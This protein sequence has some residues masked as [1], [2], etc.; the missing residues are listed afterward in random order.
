M[1]IMKFISC[2][3]LPMTILSNNITYSYEDILGIG[4]ELIINNNTNETLHGANIIVHTKPSDSRNVVIKNV[5]RQI[6][7]S[8]EYDVVSV[9][10]NNGIYSVPDNSKLQEQG[11]EVGL[12]E[13]NG[14]LYIANYRKVNNNIHWYGIDDRITSAWDNINKRTIYYPY[15]DYQPVWTYLGSTPVF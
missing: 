5:H 6:P 9:T 2:L 10:A 1:K 7:N 3:L 4:Q 13:Y 11:L 12:I 8:G 15:N 14:E